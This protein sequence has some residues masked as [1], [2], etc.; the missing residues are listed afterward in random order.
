MRYCHS[1]G[2][3]LQWFNTALVSCVCIAR[4]Y[5]HSDT[6]VHTPTHIYAHTCTHAHPKL[7]E[8]REEAY[9]HTISF[10]CHELT[11]LNIREEWSSYYK[12]NSL[13]NDTDG[14][15]W[16]RM[17]EGHSANPPKALAFS[18]SAHSSGSWVC[19]ELVIWAG[20]TS[21]ETGAERCLAGEGSVLGVHWM[22]SPDFS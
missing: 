18:E 1:L 2:N 12:H 5:I 14:G 7:W 3:I 10:N 6:L 21:S 16:S 4:T 9:W 17:R 13:F 22:R 11:D 20:Q 15:I 19:K 8:A